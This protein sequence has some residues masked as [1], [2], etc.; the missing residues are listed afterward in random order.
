MSIEC[1]H[2]NTR[3]ISY[4]GGAVFVPVCEECGRFVKADDTV[5]ISED[6]GLKDQPNATCSKCGRT[7]MVFEGF[8]EDFAT[9]A[10]V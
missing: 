4:D 6:S 8:F 9:E 2:E 7:K 5:M 1:Y 10:Q 3:R